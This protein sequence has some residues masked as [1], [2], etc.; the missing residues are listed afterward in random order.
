MYVKC[1]AWRCRESIEPKQDDNMCGFRSNRST[2]DQI[3]KIFKFSKDV[4][5]FFVDLEKS[6]GRIPR[7]NLWRVLQ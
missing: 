5:T 4:Y 6:Y 3:W 7:E 2:T 1:P